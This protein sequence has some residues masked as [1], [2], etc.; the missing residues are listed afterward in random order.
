MG[1]G[2][3]AYVY[4][5]RDTNLDIDVALKVLKPA[6][7]YD[8]V[9]EENFRREAHRA[10]KFRHPNVVA[11]HYAGKDDDIVFFSMDLLGSGLKDLLKPGAPVRP[12]I[13]IRVG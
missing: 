4:K 5:A 8:E 1:E 12:D 13:I 7:A 11:I 9:F 3:F 6:F 2:G 10:A